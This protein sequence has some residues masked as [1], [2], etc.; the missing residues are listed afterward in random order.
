[1]LKNL[2]IG[3]Q[4]GLGFGLLILIAALMVGFSI[5]GLWTGSESF[6]EYRTLARASV[7]SG[8]VQANMLMAAN[9]SKDYLYTREDKHL[10]VFHA[11]LANARTFALE[12][13][14]VIVDPA[15]RELSR[16]LVD[17]L[18]DYRAA[19]E[20]IFTLMRRR[21]AVLQ[22]TLNPQGKRMRE[23][24][25]EIMVSAFRDDD[26]EAAYVAGRAL[27]RV[28]V[29]R[30]Y[31]LKFLE[32]NKDA[33]VER[34]EAELGEGFEQSFAEMDAAIENPQR[35]DLLEDFS[36]ARR[37]YLNAFAEIVSTIRTRNTKITQDLKP[38]ESSI[39]DVSEQIKLSL[40]ADQDALGPIVQESKEATVQTV[41]IGA[42]IAL[43]VAFIIVLSIIRAITRPVAELVETVG[44]VRS[45]GD[46]AIRSTISGTDEIGVMARALNEFLAGLEAQARAIDEVSF[47]KLDVEVTPASDRDALALS[48]NRMIETQRTVSTQADVISSGDY[49]A[50]I[51]PRSSDDTLG[52]ALQRMTATLR[53]SAEDANLRDWIRTGQGRIHEACRGGLEERELAEQLVS[54][55]A[56]H[57]DA[58]RGALYVVEGDRLRCRAAFA[59]DADDAAGPDFAIGEGLVG[60]AARERRPILVD[61]IPEDYCTIRSSVG[62][63]APRSL[64]VFPLVH[65]DEL[66]GVL[67]LASVTEP[68]ERRTAFLSTVEETI[69]IA[70]RAARSRV[71]LRK[72]LDHTKQQAEELA[73]ARE[74]A[75]AANQAKGDFLA[76][77]SHEIRTPMNAI[78][79]MTELALD[80][81]LDPEQ[82]DY[83]NTV[84]SSAEALL[85]LINDILDFSKIE[86]GK[87][88][89]E[90]IDFGLR[91]AL[92]DMLNTLAARAHGKGLELAYHVPPN[93]HDALIGDVYRLQQII[94][95][96]IGNAIKFTEHGEIVVS[97]EQAEHTSGHIDLQFSVR[98]TGV[99]IAAEKLDAIFRP[100]E[101]AD[102]STTRKYGGTGLGLSISVQ[103]VQLMGGRIWAESEVGQGS[104]FHFTVRF[105][106]GQARTPEDRRQRAELLEDLPVLI[107]DDNATN[108]RILDEIFRNWRM[109]PQ[110]VDGGPAALT[111]LDRASNAGNPFQLVVSDVNMPEMDGFDLYTR[112]REAYPELPFIL[113]TSGTRRGD[114]KRCREIGVA[115]HLI[116]PVKQSLLMN[117]LVGA[118]AGPSIAVEPAKQDRPSTDGPDRALAILLAE[119]NPINQKFAIRLLEK[120]GHSVQVANNGREAVERSQ[121]ETFDLILMDVQMPEMDGFQATARIIEL[122]RAAAGGRH[123]PII[124]MTANA[125]KGDRERCFEAGM[126]GY[127]SKPVKRQ[128]LFE[129]MS[130]VLGAT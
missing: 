78:I 74:A 35:Q 31:V 108:R 42:I 19:S 126:D 1:M 24:L 114:A 87:L 41:M 61:E 22:E 91:D 58:Q 30:L 49:S 2:K 43:P 109:S 57:L 15:R 52:I 83:M 44:N 105:G 20:E 128:T 5:R 125:M 47:G 9:A 33:E 50:D 120:E 37:I 121:E 60:Q 26:S 45:T 54:A 59:T 63:A 110:S 111:A 97:V 67:E 99:G 17:S 39:A 85:T 51:S 14:T 100:F 3:T 104:T 102:V 73:H 38:L 112:V 94:V 117:A 62:Q 81:E 118:V 98:D 79:G 107:V 92:A 76:N 77:M 113:L 75:D 93:V 53:S 66:L 13:Q 4:I 12:Q 36:A 21:D 68:D 32:D 70:L 8:R 48:L 96:L 124:A 101:Q 115:A 72:L 86:A 34:V 25:T 84:R 116:K 123:T 119:D 82:R 56:D 130:R 7:L 23:D 16:D 103:L 90:P 29:G 122:E 27:G 28:L 18:D 106:V 55:L 10:D 64:I 6:K 71:E 89:I 80:T 69:C 46:L 88:E 11:R 95:N 65:E 127:V 40:K 129:E